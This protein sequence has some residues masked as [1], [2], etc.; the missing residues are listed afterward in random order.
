MIPQLELIVGQLEASFAALFA[1]ERWATGAAFK[2]GRKGF[3][4]V[5][6]RLIRSV[7]GD[8]PGPGELLSPDLIKLL[9]ELYYGGF[10][11][12]FVLSV[13]LG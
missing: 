4:Q 13:P 3:A 12:S 9:L 10:L 5:Q 6:K 2:K 7:L 8:L 11:A 1:F